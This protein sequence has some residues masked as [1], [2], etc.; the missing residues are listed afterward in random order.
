MAVGHFTEALKD[1][2]KRRG[3][4]LAKAGRAA[5]V[6][7]SQVG[8]ILKG[9]RKASEPVMRATAHH[10][11]DGQL[12]LAAAAE[13]TGGAS[14]PWLDCAD[15]HPSSAHIKTIEEIREAEQALL[16]MPITKTLE[17]LSVGD[18]Q[19]IKDSLMEQIEAITALT[20][21]ISVLCRK[22]DFSYLSL[23]EEHRNELRAKKY[24]K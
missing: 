18:R 6:D 19:S 10:Y 16:R 11:D 2:M 23:W 21:N 13:V 1:V 8:K 24:M 4:T 5:H 15:L 3:D 20:H 7:G 9:T 17:Q 12:F 22:Y 14:V